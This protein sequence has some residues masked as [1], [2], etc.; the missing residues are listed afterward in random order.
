L[1]P[2]L[3]NLLLSHSHPFVAA[4]DCGAPKLAAELKEIVSCPDTTFNATCTLRCTLGNEPRAP[5]AIVCAED[6]TWVAADG[7][8]LVKCAGV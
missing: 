3:R 7:A 2:E 5:Q 4:V 8:D 1:L 6:G